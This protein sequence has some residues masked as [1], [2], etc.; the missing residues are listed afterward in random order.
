V[1]CEKCGT[2]GEKEENLPVLLPE[3][4]NFEPSGDGTS[5]LTKI[6]SFVNCECPKC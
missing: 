5:P 2:V 3:T 4:D 1:H 6:E